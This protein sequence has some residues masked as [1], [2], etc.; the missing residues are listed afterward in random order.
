V[1]RDAQN[2]EPLTEE[3]GVPFAVLLEGV[4]VEAAAVEL[5]DEALLSPEH[6]D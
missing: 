4:A 2:G 1:R 5:D 3:V 6:V